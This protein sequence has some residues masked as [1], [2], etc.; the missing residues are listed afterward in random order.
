MLI[1]ARNG[2]MAGKAGLKWVD[3]YVF[4]AEDYVDGSAYWYDT[5]G[6]AS[7]SEMTT[8]GL[9]LKDSGGIYVSGELNKNSTRNAPWIYSGSI[10]DTAF[11]VLVDATLDF[12]TAVPNII[13]D[14]SVGN[15]GSNTRRF[16]LG[17]T[18]SGEA[19]TNWKMNGNNSGGTFN[20]TQKSVVFSPP[21]T[22]NGVFEC[23]CRPQEDGYVCYTAFNGRDT[24]VGPV[25]QLSDFGSAI[26]NNVLTNLTIGA[27]L[28]SS[29]F[30]Y[31]TGRYRSI[32]FQTLA[33]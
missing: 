7:F 12:R 5:S 1:A 16:V 27:A 32:R 25:R 20:P 23:G 10:T 8:S 9:V 26:G 22:A 18:T 3:A 6:T 11:R 28:I 14:N 30:G 15:T 21:C 13:L 2:M 31:V 24:S 33:S 29:T 17:Y 4:R 19:Y